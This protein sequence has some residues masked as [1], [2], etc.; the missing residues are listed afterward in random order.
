MHKRLLHYLKYVIIRFIKDDVMALS[1]QLAYSL[2]FS[3][4][5]FLIFIISL[6]GYMPIESGDVLTILNG[7]FPEDILNLIDNTVISVVDTRNSKIL[8]LSLIFTIWTASSGF[9]AVIRGLNMAY[10]L[11]EKRSILKL[12][13]TSFLGTIGFIIIM[14]I[15]SMLLIFGQIIGEFLMYKFSFPYEFNIFW[16][17]IRYIVMFFSINFIFAAVYKYAPSINLRWREVISGTLSATFSLV[18]VSI[19]F[20]FYVNNFSNY[21]VLYG[22]IG[23]VIALLT[24]LFI[25]SNIIILGGEINALVYRKR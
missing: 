9:Q 18:I 8:I 21:S 24:W 15:T 19:G 5:P 10:G 22:S 11:E 20:A 25:L 17:I 4:F 6:I 23:A 2:I 7:I 14:L 12:Y 16:N 13:A 1:S 3:F